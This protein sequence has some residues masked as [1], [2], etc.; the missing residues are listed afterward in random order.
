MREDSLNQFAWR[1][2]KVGIGKLNPTARVQKELERMILI[3][4]KHLGQK[5]PRVTKS[6]KD[7]E[8]PTEE[9]LYH[10]L[11]QVRR[12]FPLYGFMANVTFRILS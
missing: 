6:Y 9:F 4:S 12:V 7:R 8:A 10:L 3:R 11:Q 5:A 2:V 1:R